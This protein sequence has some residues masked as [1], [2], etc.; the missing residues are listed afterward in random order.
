MLERYDRNRW[1]F[2]LGPGERLACIYNT[3]ESF[4]FGELVSGRGAVIN[5]VVLCTIRMKLQILAWHMG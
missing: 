4:S 1:G 5:Q 2:C 3:C